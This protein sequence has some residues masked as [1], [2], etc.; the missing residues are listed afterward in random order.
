[1]KKRRK[2]LPPGSPLEW[3]DHAMSDL[4]LARLGMESADVLSEQVCFH[5]QQ[6]AEKALKAV[7][8]HQQIPFPL[9]HDLDELIE[10]ACQGGCRLPEWAN[11]L[12]NLTPYAI[13][14][15]YPGAWEAFEDTDVTDALDVARRVIE[16]VRDIVASSE[17]G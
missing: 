3:L 12:G 6:A 8:L 4:A 7:L 16:W 15:R 1:M 13:E 2:K 9:I 10:I 11:D 5:A 14:T 17:K